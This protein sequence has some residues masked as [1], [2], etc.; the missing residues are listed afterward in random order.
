MLEKSDYKSDI[1]NELAER[2]KNS[3]DLPVYKLSFVRRLLDKAFDVGDQIGWLE[4]YQEGQ[5]NASEKEVYI[6]DDNGKWHPAKLVI[7]NSILRR[8]FG[9]W[10]VLKG[11]YVA[12]RFC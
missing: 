3:L 11:D 5:S 1:L 10:H 9:V 8:L 12:V 2:A 6:Q 4:G 7:N